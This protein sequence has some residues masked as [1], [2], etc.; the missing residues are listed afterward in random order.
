MKSSQIINHILNLPNFNRLKQS[1]HLMKALQNLG[2]IRAKFIK[3]ATIKSKILYI[4]ANHPAGVQE[5]K[6]NSSIILI[7]NILEI[8]SMANEVEFDFEKIIICLEK[9]TQIYKPNLVQNQPNVRL[10]CD[11]NFINLAKDSEVYEKFEKIREVLK[12]A[13]K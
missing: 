12:N 1:T 13:S 7:K 5:L 6:H 4:F 8:Y 9:N 10:K 3:F 2:Y 11:S